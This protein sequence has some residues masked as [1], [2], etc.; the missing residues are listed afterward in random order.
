MLKNKQT[1]VEGPL[2]KLVAKTSLSADVTVIAVLEPV[3]PMLAAQL[4]QVPLPPPF[5]GVKRLPELIDAAKAELTVAGQPRSALT[6][7]TPSEQA[8]QELEKLVKQLM[9]TGQQMI[10]AQASAQMGQSDDPVEK[11]SAAYAQRMVKRIFEMFQPKR[12]G[13]VLVVAQEGA[14]TNQTA[15]I[16]VLVALLLPAV[17][18]A[19]EAARRM[20]S[21]NNLKQIA[22]AMHNFHDSYKVLS[23]TRQSRRRRNAAPELARAH[24]AVLGTGGSVQGIQTE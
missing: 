14:V 24:P 4:A 6:L 23:A 22:L 2:S 3:R 15:M 16:G 9:Q 11:A 18:A 13:N 7:L 10:L 12:K 19:R 1:P 20:Q 17:Q 5:A 21:S 8:A